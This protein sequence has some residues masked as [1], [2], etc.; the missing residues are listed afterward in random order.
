MDLLGKSNGD[1]KYDPRDI[2]GTL[3][4]RISEKNKIFSRRGAEDAEKNRTRIKRI[5]TD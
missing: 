4:L 2:I 3:Y 5:E 1:R